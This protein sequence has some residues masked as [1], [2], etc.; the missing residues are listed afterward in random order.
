MLDITPLVRVLAA[1]RRAQLARMDAKAVQE[2]TLLK[3]VRRAANTRFGK[4]HGFAAIKSVA[5]FQAR[6]PLRNWEAMWNEYFKTALPNFHNVSWPDPTPYLA[7][8]SGTTSARTKYVPVTEAMNRSNSRAGLDLLVYHWSAKPRSRIFDGKTFMLGGSTKLVPEAPGIWSGDLSGIAVKRMPFWARPYAFP[9]EEHALIPNWEEKAELMARTS[10]DEKIRALTGTPA[11]ILML[12]DR[13]RA[14]RAE[15]GERGPEYPDLELLVH[16]GVNFA[17]YRARFE[18]LFA[19]LDVDMREVYPASEGFIAIADRRYGEGLRLNLDHGLFF[20][21]V[22]LEDLSSPNPRRHWIANVET[23]VNYAVVM[24]TCAGLWAYVIGDT[25]R[26]VD[27]NPPR[28]LITG[29]TTYWLSGFGEHLLAEQIETGIAEA[30]AAI[31]AD[32]T[33]YSVSAVYERAGHLYVTEFAGG[34][35]DQERLAQ[36]AKTLD[37]TLRR[38]VNDYDYYRKDGRIVL[39]EIRP[40]PP[41]TFASWMKSRGK[42]GGQNKVPRII[43]DEALWGNLLRFVAERAREGL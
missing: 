31:G 11:W 13:V 38:I 10:L 28:I 42:L 34:P 2:K 20:E 32:V 29:R 23:G 39:P 36:F 8:S 4:D 25:V 6:I 18:R 1:R 26:F 5:D 15:R 7:L 9:K 16:G 14:L 27:K 41:G 30:A 19:G 43:N 37:A 24:S 21:F 33:D 12:L 22:P 3:L 40:V 35:P 17:P